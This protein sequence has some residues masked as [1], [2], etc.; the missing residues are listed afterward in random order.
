MVNWLINFG[1][2]E[3]DLIPIFTENH[4]NIFLQNQILCWSCPRQCCPSLYQVPSFLRQ[5]QLRLNI[6]PWPPPL[7][8]QPQLNIHLWSQQNRDKHHWQHQPQSHIDPWN[9]WN[10]LIRIILQWS[11][12]SQLFIHPWRSSES[13]CQHILAAMWRSPSGDK[14]NCSKLYWK[15]CFQAEDAVVAGGELFPHFPWQQI[16]HTDHT[17]PPNHHTATNNQTELNQP[18]PFISFGHSHHTNP[19]PALKARVQIII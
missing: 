15:H 9:R 4:W 16:D 14:N 6:Y 17:T 19:A 5:L 13:R 11:N 2:R 7:L 10:W 3:H 18:L 1:N 12:I 8:S